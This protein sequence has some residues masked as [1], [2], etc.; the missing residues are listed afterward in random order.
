[1]PTL[2]PLSIFSSEVIA[3]MEA[4][5]IPEHLIRLAKMNLGSLHGK[6]AIN[7]ENPYIFNQFM[8]GAGDDIWSYAAAAGLI[9]RAEVS[10]MNSY[11]VSIEPIE[12]DSGTHIIDPGAQ[13]A[14][15]GTL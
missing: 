3:Q 2:E 11:E 13:E 5:N 9:T 15:P 12:I 8:Y 6:I 14:Q 1:M 7:L 4:D 10:L